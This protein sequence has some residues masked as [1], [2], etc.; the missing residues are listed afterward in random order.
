MRKLVNNSHIDD[1]TISKQLKIQKPWISFFS[2]NG[3][4]I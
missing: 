4:I 3:E 2:N 1:D